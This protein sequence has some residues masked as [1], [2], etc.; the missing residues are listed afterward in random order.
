MSEMAPERPARSSGTVAADLTEILHLH[1]RLLTEATH[2]RTRDM[3]GG[4]ALAELA[5]VANLE[6]WE[7]RNETGDR[8]GPVSTSAPDERDEEE[9]AYQKVK[10]WAERWRRA[11][12]A[13]YEDLRP[14]IATEATFIRWQLN[15]ALDHEHQWEA[16]ADDIHD[17]RVILENVLHDGQR[18]I[19]SD[20]VECLL[21]QNPLRR[22]MTAR[23][24]FEDEWW[25]GECR[26]HLTT[27][28]FNLAASEAARRKLG[29]MVDDD[30]QI[31]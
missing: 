3:P 29:L 28:Q 17:A 22:R 27:A 6:A 21:C 8:G 7:H 16:F 5:P 25:C 15:W 11:H 18:D 4:R 1:A 2:A 23:A 9:P 30:N 31:G 26:V 13:D 12:D 20:E 14:T 24:G 19:V 10:F